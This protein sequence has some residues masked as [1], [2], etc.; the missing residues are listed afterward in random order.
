VII[1]KVQVRLSQENYDR[2]GNAGTVRDTYDTA[3]SEILDVYEDVKRVID[4]NEPRTQ[5]VKKMAHRI[6]KI[7][8]T[9]N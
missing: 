7:C 5:K 2:I 4:G 3:L 9:K 8:G 1:T 6:N